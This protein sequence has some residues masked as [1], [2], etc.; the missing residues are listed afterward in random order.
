MDPLSIF[1]P[2]IREWFKRRFTAPTEAQALGWPAIAQGRHTLIS[3]PTGS[4]KTL[5]AFL[6]C[7]DRLLCAAEKNELTD[8]AQV[9]YVSPLK[10]LSNDIHRNLSEPLQ[11]ISQLAGERG[12]VIPDIRIA[13]RTGDTPAH[14]RQMRARKPPHIWITTPESLYILLTSESGRRGLA[15]VHTLILDEIHS[16]AGNKRGSYLALSVERLCALAGRPIVR[17]GLSA[18]IRPIR[19]VA[20]FLVGTNE[21]NPDG[22]PRCTIVDTGHLREMDLQIEMPDAELGPIATLELLDETISRIASLI[23]E[24]RTTLVFVN[25]RRLVERIAHRLSLM[26]GEENIVAHHGSLSQKTRLQAEER[27]KSGSVQVCVA[28]ASLELGIDIG[29]VDLVC[30]LGSP[31]SIGV[32]LQRVGRSGHWLGGFPR[33]RV[34]PLTRDELIECAALIYAIRRGVLDTIS[35]PPWPLDILAQQIVAMCAA[36]DWKAEDLFRILCGAYAYRALPRAS[37]DGVVKMLSEGFATQLG[38]RS[39]YLH[40]DSIHGILRGRRG[41]RL[42]ALTSGGAIPDNANY[43]VVAEP[44]GT[45]VGSVYEDFAAESMAGEVFLLGNTSWRI[46]RIEKGRV[47]VEDAHGQAPDIPFWRGEAPARTTELSQLISEVREG[48]DLRMPDHGACLK[49]LVEEVGVSPNGA[50]Q[51]CAYIMEGKRILGAVPGISNVVAERF[52][53]ETGG[54]QLVL[55]APFGARINKAW[56]LA[57]RKRICGRYNAELQASATDDGINLSL[58]PRH[59]FPLN[60]LLLLLS[61]ENLDQTL[62][63]AVLA[64]PIFITRWRWTVTRSLAL[65]RFVGG[66]RVPPPLQRMRSDD[67]LASVLPDSAHFP[68][69]GSLL[70]DHPLLFE[71]LRD[72]LHDAMDSEGL[73]RVLRKIECGEIQFSGRDT[74]MPS[75][76]S[77]QILNAMPYAFLDNAPIEER[78]ARAVILRRALP[79]HA[80]ELGT[81]NPDAIRSASEDAWP[82]VRDAEELHD[83]LLGLILLPEGLFSRFPERAPE[84]MDMLIRDGRAFNLEINGRKYFAATEAANLLPLKSENNREQSSGEHPLVPTIRG[85]IEVSGPLTVAGLAGMLGFPAE[86]VSTALAHLENT[87]LVLRGFFTI[88]D[89]EEFCDRRILARIHRATIAHLRREIEPVAPAVFLSFLFEWQHIASDAQLSGEQGVLEAIDQLQGFESAGAAWEDEILKA[90]VSDYK[91]EFLDALCLGGDVIWGR[92]RRRTTQAE[93]PARR[94]GITR[95]A[96]LG[97]G[98]RE[99]LP[100]LL[101][102]NPADETALS[103]SAR[104]ILEFLHS[105]GASFFPEI[106]AGTRHLPSEVEEA[107]WQLVAA[108]LVTADSFAALRS[109]VTGE[110]KKLE[111]SRRRRRQPR[112]TREGRWSLLEV[113]GS[114]PADKA[115]FWAQ[116]YI[117]RYGI[118]CRELLVRETSA[119]PWRELLRVLRRSEARGEIRGGR[120]IAGLN[121]EQFALPEAVESLRAL[122]RKPIQGRYVRISACDPLNLAGILTPGARITAVLGNRILYRDGVPVAAAENTQI[123]LLASIEPEERTIVNRLLDERPIV[124]RDSKFEIR[125]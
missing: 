2:V 8:S 40:Y 24:Q 62:I 76:F 74:P 93:V 66:K 55:H 4:G 82:P 104:D 13:V 57:L 107:L 68:E 31:R 85:W 95:A 123:R 59:S 42:A 7:I 15:G 96:P 118:F 110:T 26:I 35:I 99:D 61:P 63:Q 56:G 18:T 78:R 117:R 28:T 44:D 98:I 17:I 39:A 23:R 32:L 38:R 121:G 90:R 52:F 20:H 21:L 122:R 87:G 45:Y 71:A 36:E 34:F 58:G 88:Q 103:N 49:W 106:S 111:H 43:D 12:L 89:E 120:F 16:I 25:T 92:W 69:G 9:V 27:L 48:I 5:A 101:D 115:E 70:P 77:H 1:H 75:V 41:A 102:E 37:F 14:E 91:P 51:A 84:W 6:L 72:C 125:D 30:Q 53:D 46:R 109:L 83:A 81:L 64:S 119:P 60:D 112:R 67:L 47:L 97:L 116:Q 94:P 105:H 86:E 108:G 79:E 54:M 29:A 10:A 114:L 22:T 73:R 113:K 124:I 33:G 65:L 3:A 19:E 11:E 80:D 100:W 50:E